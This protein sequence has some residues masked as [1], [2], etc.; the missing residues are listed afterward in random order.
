MR[1]YNAHCALCRLMRSLAFAGLGMALGGGIPRL[2]GASEQIWL[3]AGLVT[4]AILV[5]GSQQKQPPDDHDP[6]HS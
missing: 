6:D 5:F 3:S 1:G 2:L 4:A